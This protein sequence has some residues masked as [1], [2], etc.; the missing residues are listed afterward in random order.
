MTPGPN[1]RTR[2]AAA[3][4]F[5]DATGLIA[6]AGCDPRTLFY[7]LQP[8]EPTVPAP[9]P[10]LDEKRVVL[11]TNTV[12]GSL[13]E[14]SS[15]DREI[16]REVSSILREKVKKIDMVD[17]DKVLK[18]TEGHPNWTDPAELAKAFEA[19]IVIFLE[20][21]QFQVQNPADLNVYQ[22]TARTHIMVTEYAHPKNSKGKVNKNKPK[23]ADSIYDDYRDTEF[24]I[25]GPIPMDSGVSK[26][27]FKTKFMKV[28]ATEISWHF[29]D[30][31]PEDDV[32]DV[33]VN[34]R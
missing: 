32:Q 6:I 7:F 2:R 14:Y 3:S 11:V 29:V 23:E 25:R 17:S 10:K 28:V 31:T 16:S 20:V 4:L 22:G 18:W 9:G 15:V 13:G 19:D 26:N 34:G 24:P 5:I 30:H 27:A 12:S 1:A 21:E 33:K 8:N